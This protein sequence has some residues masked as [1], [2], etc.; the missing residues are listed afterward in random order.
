[1]KGGPKRGWRQGYFTDFHSSNFRSTIISLEPCALN[2][3][4]QDFI[5]RFN[6]MSLLRDFA[7]T[8]E[9][10]DRG[11]K[12]AQREG[13]DRVTLRITLLSYVYFSI[14]TSLALTSEIWVQ[15]W[16]FPHGGTYFLKIRSAQ[17][18]MRKNY[19]LPHIDTCWIV[20]IKILAWTM[21]HFVRQSWRPNSTRKEQKKLPIPKFPL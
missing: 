6:K 11:W 10:E 5:L 19:W 15:P 14:N 1:M 3:E 16:K 13:E 18:E 9:R 21:N 20:G 17:C 8:I 7:D 4:F 2:A 12:E